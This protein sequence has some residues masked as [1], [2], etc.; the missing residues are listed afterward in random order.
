MRRLCPL[1]LLAAL[2]LG[3]AARRP[4]A[5]VCSP[6]STGRERNLLLGTDRVQ[7]RIAQSYAGRSSWPSIPLGYVYDDTTYSTHWSFDDQS[8]TDRLGGGYFGGRET[9]RTRVFVR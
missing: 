1:L 9:I 3:C 5:V 8:F 6:D 7:A 4:A 2:C